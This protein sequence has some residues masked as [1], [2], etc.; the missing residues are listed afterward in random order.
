MTKILLVEDEQ[1]MAEG[2]RDALEHHGF[3]VSN[4]RDA[5]EGEQLLQEEQFDLII[6]DV[7]LPGKDG[8]ETCLS[9]RKREI[10]IPIIMLTARNEEVDK[11]VGLE[12]GA[13]DYV[14]KPFSMRELIA[15][16]KAHLRRSAKDDLNQNEYTFGNI[17]VDFAKHMV[18]RNNKDIKL[19]SIEFT[20]LKFLIKER[21]NVISRDKILNEVWGYSVYPD[22]RSVDTHILNLRSKLEEDPHHPEFIKTHHG[23]GYQFVG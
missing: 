1:S 4:V 15:R 18:S 2:I 5:E 22:S 8:F 3:E 17:K 6:L 7:M 14:T 13:D 12:L 23:V 10:K 19:T 11:V 16:V 20:L 9:I 21:H